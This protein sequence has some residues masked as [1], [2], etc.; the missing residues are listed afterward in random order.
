MGKCA[1]KLTQPLL[2]ETPQGHICQLGLGCFSVGLKAPT[3]CCKSQGQICC[4]V[5]NAAFP[6]DDEV[7][8]T[9]AFLGLVCCPHFGFLKTLGELTQYNSTDGPDRHLMK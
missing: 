2:C 6:P 1:L 3:T 7:P 5:E 4:L 9:C 8:C